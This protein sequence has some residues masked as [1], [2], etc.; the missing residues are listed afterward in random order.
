MV[1]IT[2]IYTLK[3]TVHSFAVCNKIYISFS[4]VSQKL[5]YCFSQITGPTTGPTAKS[6]DVIVTGGRTALEV[7]KLLDS[8]SE[9]NEVK[10][11]LEQKLHREQEHHCQHKLLTKRLHQRRSSPCEYAQYLKYS[12]YTLKL[13]AVLR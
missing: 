10:E 13:I 6:V 3:S 1:S 2:I 7:I 11:Y 5:N 4:K 8:G 12:V 9:D